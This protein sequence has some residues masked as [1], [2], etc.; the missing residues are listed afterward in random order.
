MLKHNTAKKT[1]ELFLFLDNIDECKNNVNERN[2]VL[3]SKSETE[4]FGKMGNEKGKKRIYCS[5][6]S[7]GGDD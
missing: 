1:K 6:E 2:K 4:K 7:P 5:L 3:F